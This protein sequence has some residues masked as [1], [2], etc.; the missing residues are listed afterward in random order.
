MR[1]R[2]LAWLLVAV[3]FLVVSWRCLAAGDEASKFTAAA[4]GGGGGVGTAGGGPGGGK[5][6]VWNLKRRS[7]RTRAWLPPAPRS[8]TMRA[9]EAPKRPPP[10]PPRTF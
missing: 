5:K 2:G 10:S 8:N 4:G 1:R 3:V 6:P 9:M 7:L